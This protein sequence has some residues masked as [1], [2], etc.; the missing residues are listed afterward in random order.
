ML[1]KMAEVKK[2]MEGAR[3]SA[4]E[5]YDMSVAPGMKVQEIGDAEMDEETNERGEG[6]T[7]K[8][9]PERKTK[10]QRKKAA[11]V[12]AEVCLL[13]QHSQGFFKY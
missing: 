3:V 7:S 5:E 6:E 8:K 1:E 11:R 12:L 2:K 4:L 10:S 13:Y 9:V